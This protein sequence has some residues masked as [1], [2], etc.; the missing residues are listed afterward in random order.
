VE[1]S[2]AASEAAMLEEMG[3][4]PM[5]KRGHKTEVSV[6][7]VS[8]SGVS[9]LAEGSGTPLGR[10]GMSLDAMKKTGVRSGDIEL[11]EGLGRFLSSP[12]RHFVAQVIQEGMLPVFIIAYIGKAK[13]TRG[14]K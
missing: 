3:T 4:V 6:G 10:I 7:I 9:A 5:G 11:R 12:L 13:S 1:I 2:A 8:E 14:S